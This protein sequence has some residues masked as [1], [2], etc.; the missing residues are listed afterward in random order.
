[1]ATQPSAGVALV[2]DYYTSLNTKIVQ[3]RRLNY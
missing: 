3:A 2:R 1:V